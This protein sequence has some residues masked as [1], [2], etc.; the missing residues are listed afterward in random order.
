VRELIQN[1][2]L[3]RV[4]CNME[5]F[6]RPPRSV[7]SDGLTIASASSGIQ[8]EGALEKN[9]DAGPTS[10]EDINLVAPRTQD[11]QTNLSIDCLCAARIG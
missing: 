2:I 8:S 9:V 1:G 7:P 3:I 10:S 5:S 4:M 11:V 6:E